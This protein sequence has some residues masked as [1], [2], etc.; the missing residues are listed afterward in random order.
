MERESALAGTVHNGFAET[1]F[2]PAPS[3]RDW[4]I[5]GL[6]ALAGTL[7]HILTSGNYGYFR[8]EL[9]FAAC[10]RRLSW[11][12]VDHAPFIV[13]VTAFM[14]KVFGDSLYS[15]RFIPALTSGGKVLL[16]AWMAREFGGRRF[17]ML[18][19][20]V[21]L[22][23]CP[24]YL[25]MD[26]YLSMN[27]VEPLLW[28][29]SIAV[30]MRMF[31]G[32]SPR[33][34]LLFGAIAGL[35]ILN[36]HSTLLFGF[37]LVLAI[38]ISTGIKHFRTPW[39]W[40][41][42]AVTFLLFLPN[43]LWE[44]RHH[45]PTIEILSNAP[46]TKNA[47]VP[48]Y[49]FI[50]E[51]GLLVGPLAVP[52]VLG[53]LWWLLRSER[54]R[55]FRFVGW[56][57]IFLLTL[58]VVLAAR[59]YYLAPIYPMLFAAGAVWVEEKVSERGWA[60]KAVL[61][62]L[63]VA[64]LIVIP[65]AVPLLPIDAAAAYAQFWRVNDVRVETYDSGKLP[66]FFSDMF[67]W[68]EQAAVIAHVFYSLPPDE[69]AHTAI[70]LGNYGEA[71]AIDFFGPALGLPQATSPHNSYWYWGPP[72]DS[73][74]TAIALNIQPDVLRSIYED[75]QEVAKTNNAYAMR[76]EDGLPVYLCRHPKMTL[77]QA[78]PRLRVIL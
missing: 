1:A 50:G 37:A 63:V 59:I 44:I 29:G 49:V 30:I 5:V 41:G 18:L 24:I 27:S 31:N 66:Q 43:L 39:I 21:L 70:L 68:R 72:P 34:W 61:V 11:G 53:G 35:G 9:Y 12:Y 4:T 46:F 16:T 73:K 8:D 58:M 2:V 60:R 3:R 36:K 48:W 47:R 22:L 20:A 55:R 71:S 62:P 17:A 28:M 23:F 42:G 57:Y 56:T 38:L 15:L 76:A 74:E 51:Q 78:W 75:V 65:L 13:F 54:A 67:G 14:R 64:G 69:R 26:S 19:S 7:L 32:G 33:L 40:A 52:I 10:A 45:F 25:A 77:A 6:L